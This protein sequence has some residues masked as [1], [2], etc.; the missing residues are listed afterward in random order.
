MWVELNVRGVPS[1]CVVWRGE[2][3]NKEDKTEKVLIKLTGRGHLFKALQMS[4]H[5]FTFCAILTCWAVGGRV[6]SKTDEGSVIDDED[7]YEI[8]NL[9]RSIIFMPCR[10]LKPS[11]I[12]GNKLAKDILYLLQWGWWIVPSKVRC[13][14][15]VAL[16]V[17][18]SYEPLCVCTGR[19]VRTEDDG[20]L[21]CTH[22]SNGNLGW[23]KR[24]AINA[25]RRMN[26]R[27][28]GSPLPPSIH[29]ILHFGGTVTLALGCS[30]FR[31]DESQNAMTALPRFVVVVVDGWRRLFCF[32]CWQVL[33]NKQ[34]Q[35]Q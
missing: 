12:S 3:R 18:S 15:R 9:W 27:M 34:A 14:V 7:K 25:T 13:P 24:S 29:P 26:G 35:Q 16:K 4:Y 17:R 33:F 5:S 21:N 31:L 30:Y 2:K 11:Q 8:A 1:I 32:E 6:A 23:W 19:E 28:T 22:I 10:N 20:Q